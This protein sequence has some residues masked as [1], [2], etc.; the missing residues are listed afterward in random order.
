MWPQKR[1]IGP[2]I[3]GNSMKQFM[4]NMMTMMMPAMV[5][6]VY[7]GGIMVVL[8][9][10]LY[11]LAGRLGYKLPLWMSRGAMAFG[12]FFLVAQVMG[13]ILGAAPS[14]NF[15]DPR[16]FEFILYAFWQIG[17]AL[18]IPGW[19]MWSLTSNRMAKAES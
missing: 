16:Q 10:I 17:L 15:G 3:K 12:I 8:A 18:L 6:M 5:P 7:I 19:I 2:N 13:L 14:I 4:L 9:V 11:M 1:A